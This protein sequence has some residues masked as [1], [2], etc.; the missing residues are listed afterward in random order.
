VNIKT[1]DA[2]ATSGV[3]ESKYRKFIARLQE[4][5]SQK[6]SSS[7]HRQEFSLV[8]KDHIKHLFSHPGLSMLTSISASTNS[9]S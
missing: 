3:P 4:Q 1:Q 8:P 5:Q 2:L 7:T 6:I 9:Y